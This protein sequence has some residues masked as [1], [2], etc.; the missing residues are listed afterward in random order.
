MKPRDKESGRVACFN[1]APQDNSGK[2]NKL[3]KN[4]ELSVGEMDIAQRKGCGSER[5][6]VEWC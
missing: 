2:K 3:K 6:L 1:G 4:E 5:R